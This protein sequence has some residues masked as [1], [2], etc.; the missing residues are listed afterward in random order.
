MEA[1]EMKTPSKGYR[2]KLKMEQQDGSIL[3]RESGYCT[4]SNH[5]REKMDYFNQYLACGDKAIGF[6]MSETILPEW[7]KESER[8]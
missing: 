7:W 4:D 1:I 2:L 3:Y 8:V 5:A 6:L